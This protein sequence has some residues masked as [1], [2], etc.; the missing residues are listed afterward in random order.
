[1][2]ILYGIGVGPGDP[3]YLTL[4]AVRLIKESDMI[5]LSNKSK[6][7]CYAYQIVKQVI[8]EIQE[9]KIVCYDFP[10]VKES[11]LRQSVH[12]DI[13]KEVNQ[14]LQTGKD[15]AF[16]TIGDPSVYSTYNYIHKRV[17]QNGGKAEMIS[18][19]PSFCAVAARLGIP[20][21]ENHEE[22]HILPGSY[23]ENFPEE[24]LSG[25][26]IYMKS[27]RK[28]EDLIFYLEQ[29]SSKRKLIIRAVS[30][31]GLDNEK[32]YDSLDELKKDEKK[33]YLTVLIVK[34]VL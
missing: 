34:E 2:G 30:N 33:N 24:H 6:E 3:E 15:V 19:V 16:L 1:M 23:E 22:I 5:V 29:Q 20:L 10:M 27:G 17:V 13:Y 8:P 12:D 32:V 14:Y 9:K 25:T 28:L 31:C 11:E 4:K 26:H 21:A 18:G 7:D